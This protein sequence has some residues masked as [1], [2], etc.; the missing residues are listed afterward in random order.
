ML[1]GYVGGHGCMYMYE[2]QR[3]KSSIYTGK[4]R[5]QEVEGEIEKVSTYD[6]N[7]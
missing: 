3:T 5:K 2:I 4:K 1:C 6:Q 7:I